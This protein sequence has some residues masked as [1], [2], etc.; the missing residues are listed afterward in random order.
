MDIHQGTSPAD[1][2]R[3]PEP[4]RKKGDT[5]QRVYHQVIN[6]YRYQQPEQQQQR[7]ATPAAM[8]YNKSRLEINTTVALDTHYRLVIVRV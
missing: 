5:T 8:M 7:T 4:N 1:G 3:R 6:N 2:G